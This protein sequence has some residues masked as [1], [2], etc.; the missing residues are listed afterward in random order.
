MKNSFFFP[1]SNKSVQFSIH[2]FLWLFEENEILAI[3]YFIGR[4][5]ALQADRNITHQWIPKWR[6]YSK[7]KQIPNSLAQCVRS[8]VKIGEYI[9][10]H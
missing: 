8:Q 10:F 3:S 2:F 9:T 5:I 1:F 7:C 4:G 6:A